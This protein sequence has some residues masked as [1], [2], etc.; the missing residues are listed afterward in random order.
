MLVKE[1]T[2]PLA[3]DACQDKSSI[4]A[5]DVSDLFAYKVQFGHYRKY[6]RT[7]YI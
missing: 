1:A 4:Q 2:G 5:E 7:T 6:V 3:R